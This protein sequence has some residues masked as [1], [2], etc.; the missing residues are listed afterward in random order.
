[1][2]R[3]GLIGF[4][5]ADFLRS[6]SSA[7]KQTNFLWGKIY[8]IFEIDYYCTHIDPGNPCQR[9]CVEGDVAMRCNCTFHI[10]YYYT[11]SKACYDFP[12]IPADCDR[13]YCIAADGVERGCRCHQPS[14][15]SSIDSGIVEPTTYN[16]RK[17]FPQQK[18]IICRV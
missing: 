11:M 2:V 9:E 8:V 18:Y 1:M 14:N 10:E 7:G 12:N 13:T 16:M 3:F 5:F 4:L 17:K 15:A 6:A